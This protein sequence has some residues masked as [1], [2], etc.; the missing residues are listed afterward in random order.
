M[1]SNLKGLT[2]A[3]DV[4]GVP[5]R[6]AEVNSTGR[7]ANS[8]EALVPIT[9]VAPAEDVHAGN[10][11]S[12]SGVPQVASPG[13]S[14]L[15]EARAPVPGGATAMGLSQAR[16]ALLRQLPA[17]A[18]AAL[19]DVWAGAGER[20]EGWYLRAGALTALGLAE[21]GDAVASRGLAKRPSSVALRFL[22][23]LARSV[24]GDLR[25]AHA[26]VAAALDLT[27]SDPVLR[28]QR[29]IILSR[30]GRQQEARRAVADVRK[31]YPHHPA[32]GWARDMIR[33]SE[34][35]RVRESA[36]QTI[37]M[38]SGEFAVIDPDL[39]ESEEVAPSMLGVEE[40][41]SDGQQNG[42][43]GARSGGTLSG[44]SMMSAGESLRHSGVG[45][46]SGAGDSVP[47]DG[48][49]IRGAFEFIGARMVRHGDGLP[50]AEIRSLLRALSSGGVLAGCGSPEL[51]HGART[52]AGQLLEIDRQLEYPTG[53]S[54]APSS[55]LASV[56]SALVRDG[57][58]QASR[59]W[60]CSCRS[61]PAAVRYLVEAILNGAAK[62]DTNM[63]PA[64]WDRRND[65]GASSALSTAVQGGRSD[66]GN[67]VLLP[68]RYGLSLLAGSRNAPGADVSTRRADDLPPDTLTLLSRTCAESGELPPVVSDVSFDSSAGVP[69]LRGEDVHGW[70]AWG[71][72]AASGGILDG[73]RRDYMRRHTAVESEVAGQAG[74]IRAVV[75]LC[76]VVAATGALLGHGAVGALI[77]LAV[78]W[79]GARRDRKVE[80]RLAGGGADIAQGSARTGEVGTQGDRD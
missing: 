42:R 10:T 25:G 21:E 34:S 27:P 6:I 19:D 71:V 76:V 18:L 13:N 53:G 54:Q 79:I 3:R 14:D 31:V 1:S 80:S 11:A 4:S 51:M 22:Q 58:V 63:A 12:G 48:D 33:A 38:P 74:A 59:V 75:V 39:A 7:V 9:R 66:R 29:A 28:L 62:T 15:L 49:M 35:D 23:S 32:L 61:L 47:D 52:L 36:L 17:D 16:A 41:V 55:G 70:N 77:A 50:V 20:E 26:A 2:G 43:S 64:R 30:Q 78:V 67:E 46:T 8:I 40:V 45:S 44:A 56:V 69:R 73:A 57:F 68:V 60:R 24:S 65:E 37:R 5:H 72:I